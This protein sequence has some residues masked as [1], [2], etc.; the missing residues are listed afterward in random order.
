MREACCVAV[1]LR[2]LLKGESVAE[3][4]LVLTNRK[5]RVHRQGIEKLYA[6]DHAFVPDGTQVRTS[7]ILIPLRQGHCMAGADV[8]VCRKMCSTAQLPL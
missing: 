6:V 7:T 2:P 1:R 3:D 8:L 4:R 5:V